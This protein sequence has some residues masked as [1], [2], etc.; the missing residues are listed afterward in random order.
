MA[1]EVI[2]RDGEMIYR[3]PLNVLLVASR[4]ISQYSFAASQ[5]RTHEFPIR[6]AMHQ[7]KHPIA[8]RQPDS[9][10]CVDRKNVQCW[11]KVHFRL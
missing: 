7:A 5:A 2:R 6:R 10:Q 1:R 3:A 8:C 9:T 4:F 11:L